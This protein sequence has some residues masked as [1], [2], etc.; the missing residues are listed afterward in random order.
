M[1]PV[2]PT[3]EHLLSNAPKAAALATIGLGLS[4][5]LIPQQAGQ[6]FGLGMVTDG[7][8]LWLARLVGVANVTTGSWRHNDSVR[9]QVRPRR[10]R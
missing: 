1:L 4:Q 10:R 8:T 3:K 7:S 6:A 2:D 9:T 5:S